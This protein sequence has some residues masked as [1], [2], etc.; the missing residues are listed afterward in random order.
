MLLKKSKDRAQPQA[1]ADQKSISATTEKLEILKTIT[2]DVRNLSVAAVLSSTIDPL[3]TTASATV[4]ASNEHIVSSPA[5]TS[6]FCAN[7]PPILT[8]K[9]TLKKPAYPQYEHPSKRLDTYEKWQN[10]LPPT[11]KSLVDAGFFYNKKGK[12]DVCCF[13]CG[14][15]LND[16]KFDDNAWKEHARWFP[17]CEFVIDKM[18]EKCVAL[19]QEELQPESEMGHASNI[20]AP[21]LD[22]P[23]TDHQRNAPYL[24]HRRT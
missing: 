16:W 21:N 13:C 9:G 24:F 10:T 12:D 22:T 17:K 14:N 11:P 20:P 19:I 4:V 8:V 18:G 1:E 2:T 3:S 23:H 5:T 6:S 15:F 7:R